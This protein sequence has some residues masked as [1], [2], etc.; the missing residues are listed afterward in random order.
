MEHPPP[1]P[2][3]PRA[4]DRLPLGT[5][6]LGV[7]PICIGI[8]GSS[9]VVPAAFDAGINFFFVSA[10][11]HWPLYEGVRGGLRDLFA[12]A[13]GL[14]DEVVVA[15]V[16]YLG[17]PFFHYLQFHEVIHA[18]PGMDRVDLLVAGGIA[19]T[20]MLAERLAV[21]QIARDHR[22]LG[23]RAIG[24]SFHDR[25]TALASINTDALDIHFIRYNPAHTGADRDLFPHMKADRR[26]PIFNFKSNF[27]KVSRERLRDMGRAS[28]QWLPGATDHYRF[29]LGNP[30]ID[31]VLCAPMSVA[32]LH[33]LLEALEDRPLTSEEQE[34]MRNLAT[35]ARAPAG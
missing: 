12:R 25:R 21:L 29:A 3:L 23:S 35:G 28:D 17:E 30:G 10:D 4:T 31:G 19:S 5:T 18:V 6:G 27:G 1:H 2:R 8:T 16:S 15:V 11:L 26:A 24:G 22:H 33:Q 34:Y 9:A 14:R 7:S 20:D 13:G 32:E